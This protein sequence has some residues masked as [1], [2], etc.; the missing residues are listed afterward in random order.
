MDVIP[1]DLI[2]LNAY[3]ARANV[4]EERSV[5]EDLFRID[6]DYYRR[7]S[8]SSSAGRSRRARARTNLVQSSLGRED[9]DVPI[10]TGAGTARHLRVGESA[11]GVS[12]DA[13]DEKRR[14]TTQRRGKIGVRRDTLSLH[15]WRIA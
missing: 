8:T 15:L 3:S 7:S 10:V 5:V 9:G 14:A 1:T 6:S 2:A 11:C 13:R 12:E 4:D